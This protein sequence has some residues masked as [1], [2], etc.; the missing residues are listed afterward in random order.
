MY[1]RLRIHN[2]THR[3]KR[4]NAQVAESTFVADGRWMAMTDAYIPSEYY[5]FRQG[6]FAN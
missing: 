5:P 2:K 6:L 1:E 3:N 4:Y